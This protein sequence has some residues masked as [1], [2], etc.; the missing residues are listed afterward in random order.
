[1]VLHASQR[2]SAE[3]EQYLVLKL[4]ACDY[5]SGGI[6]GN[7]ARDQPDALVPDGVTFDSTHEALVFDAG[8]DVVRVPLATNPSVFPEV[9]Y[10]VWVKVLGPMS[11][12]F[13]W[14]LT[15]AP[16]YGWSR[17]ITLG[18]YRLG[19]VSITTSSY[20]D[21]TL[22]PAPSNEWLH[23]VGV[24]SQGE[25]TVYLNGVQGASTEARNGRGSDLTEALFIG[26]R[27]PFDS[28]HNP[29]VAISD[30]A[31]YSK[32]LSNADVW[33]LFLSGRARYTRDAQVGQDQ[34]PMKAV[35]DDAASLMWFS[36]GVNAYDIPDGVE[37]QEEF[38]K[39]LGSVGSGILPELDAANPA[40]KDL[41]PLESVVPKRRQL[42]A[43]KSEACSATP[44]RN[45][46]S[47]QL[48]RNPSDPE[49][50]VRRAAHSMVLQNM[51]R[52][53]GRSVEV[54][55]RHIALF[56]FGA[57]VFAV[58]ALCPH[59]GGSLVDGEIGDIE[60]MV[61]GNRCYVTCPVHKFQ[62]DLRTGTVLQ[63][64]C[65]TLSTYAVRVCAEGSNVAMVEVGF[66]SLAPVF[67]QEFGA[68][69]F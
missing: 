7:P 66:K 45:L 21:S 17:A 27:S 18:D 38:R 25:G 12:N 57:S 63:G 47:R 31:V 59:Q 51:S 14:I 67:F 30:V 5:V 56:R 11:G 6:W 46:F 49:K 40:D 36:T 44:V 26:G 20:W 16:D 24:W 50:M 15:Q 43:H 39:K 65:G 54:H 1:M 58:D 64:K 41:A 9:S 69:D 4:L 62:F 22:G 32:A 34:S 23:V 48:A 68:D 28:V 13:G 37:W 61:E 33:E 3:L 19:H 53:S 55:G 8:G 52:R 2:A 10:A 60:D 35:W 42:Q 29:A